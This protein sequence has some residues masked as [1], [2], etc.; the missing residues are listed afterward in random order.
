M[1]YFG[2]KQSDIQDEMITHHFVWK[3]STKIFD[4]LNHIGLGFSYG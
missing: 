3:M 4:E 2:H 1:I